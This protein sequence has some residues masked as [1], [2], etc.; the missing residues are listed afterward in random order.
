MFVR[1]FVV[2]LRSRCFTFSTSGS[3]RTVHRI[4]T[5]CL[6]SFLALLGSVSV[7][8]SSGLDLLRAAEAAHD[9][10]T[11]CRTM[12]LLQLVQ[13]LQATRRFFATNTSGETLD[14]SSP[15]V[16]RL[17]DEV[18][19]FRDGRGLPC[20]VEASEFCQE[21]TRPIKEVLNAS[22]D[23]D[24]TGSALTRAIEGLLD[25]WGSVEESLVKAKQNSN[26]RD[27]LSARLLVAFIELNHQRAFSRHTT[28]SS[29]FQLRWTRTLSYLS[30]ARVMTERLDHCWLENVNQERD[31]GVFDTRLWQ[32]SG[33]GSDN[34]SGSRT[35]IQVLVQTQRCL[36]GRASSALLSEC[37]S[38][39]SSLSMR[40]CLLA[41]ACL[42][43]PAV[44]FSFKQM[45]EWI[46]NYA[47]RLKEKSEDLK[48][49][50]QLAEDLLHQ[51]LPKSVAKQLRKH[52]HVEAESYERVSGLI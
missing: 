51:M 19:S 33:A 11:S 43:Y 30:L 28:T 45:T 24:S 39:S 34:L 29:G 26:W 20:G 23:A 5:A 48:R 47:G 49:Q 3:N 32:I 6:L 7:D 8:F 44:M 37:R 14:T 9:E 31:S 21:T 52:K 40:I 1:L 10:L 16:D 38:M 35:G 46:Q 2:L 13:E 42:I 15:A 50:R 17:C 25:T 18:E 27:V 36:L 12:T 4:L 41:L 22:F